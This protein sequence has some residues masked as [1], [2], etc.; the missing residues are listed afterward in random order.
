MKQKPLSLRLRTPGPK[1]G[2][3]LCEGAFCRSG[4]CWRMPAGRL[5]LF[6]RSCRE[7]KDLVR[8][9]HWPKQYDV[10][11]MLWVG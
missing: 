7:F 6:C 11:Q 8:P 2:G 10:K 4:R 5:T 1:N 9:G 3:E